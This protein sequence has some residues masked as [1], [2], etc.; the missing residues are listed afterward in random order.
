LLD[1]F[2]KMLG[3]KTKLVAVGQMSNALGTI[4][5]VKK[6]AEMAHQWN[7]RILVDGAQAVPHM[8]VDVR[9]LDCDFYVFSGHKVF[10]PTGIGILYGKAELLEA[11][12]PYQG[13]GDMIS[14]VTFGKT[15]YNTIPYKFEAGTPHIEGVIGLGAALDY[16][17]AV[18]MDR[19]AA[20]EGELLA[21][22]TRVLS[23]AP[24]V[25]II[26]TARQ[27]GGILSFIM[28]RAH[29]HDIATILDREG[30]AIRAGHHCAMP[31]MERFAVPATARASL[32]FYNTKEELDRLVIALDRVRGIFR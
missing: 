19:I 10:G 28:D 17:S 6:I 21:H 13:G 9:D 1:E 32:A 22:G 25:K 7:A 12:P 27:K 16:V 20:Y 26:G 8:P 23:A 14:W 31:V 18:G 2:E 5:P 24:G 29:P 30:I 15:L 11:M 3:K 4:N